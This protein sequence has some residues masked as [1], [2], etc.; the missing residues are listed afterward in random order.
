MSMM[1]RGISEA[2]RASD[3]FPRGLAFGVVT[4]NED[5][6]G[7]GRVRVRLELH[8]EGQQSFWARVATPMAGPEIGFYALP[9]KDDEVLVGFIAEDASHPVVLGGVWNGRRPPPETNDDGNNDRRLFRSRSGHE[10]R[11][12]DGAA[13][14]IE[15]K[16]ADGPRAHLTPDVALIEDANGNKVEISS[17]GTITIEATQAIEIK[18]PQVK[19][20]ATRAELKGSANCKIEGALVELN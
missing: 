13:P 11:F 18:A 12:D 2:D 14:E 1:Q 3:G 20:D 15:L 4:E 5:P 9:E 16:L 10:L 19:I 6:E 17:S 8:A 7:L